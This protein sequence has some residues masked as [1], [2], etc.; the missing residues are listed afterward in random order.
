MR[1]ATGAA[2]LCLAA[3]VTAQTPGEPEVRRAIPVAPAVQPDDYEN[4][5]WVQ[6]VSPAN[7]T[8]TP[9]P[10]GIAV[11]AEP[12]ATPYRPPARSPDAAPPAPPAPPAVRQPEEDGSIRIAPANAGESPRAKLDLAN[13]LYSRK[14]FD[15][16]IPEYELYLISGSTDS[17]DAA[18]FRLA[19][20]H[21]MLGNPSAARAGYEKLVMEFHKGE[22]AG[23][24]AYRLGEIL[25]AAGIYDAACLQ[26][27][28]ASTEAKESEVRLTAK[29]FQARSL[30]YLK[31][32]EEA[33]AAYRSVA[34]AEGKNPYREH[35]LMAL[36][37]IDIR[38]GRKEEGFASLVKI[39][40]AKSAL[41][42]EA[43]VK[44]AAL[45]AELGRRDEALKLFDKIAKADDAPDWKPVALI[46]AMRLRY[47]GGDYRGVIAMG[48]GA[49]EAMPKD[50][51][52]EAFQLLAASYRQTGNNLEAR[53]TY[54]RLLKDF[55]DAAPAADARLQRLISLYALNDK[56]LVAEVD[57]FLEK[58]TDP[59]ARTQAGLLK[60][61]TFYKAGNF[62]AAG[63]LYKNL[64]SKDMDPAL[65]ADVLFKLGW[66]LSSTG[67]TTG[68]VSAFSEF[69]EKYPAHTLAAG[70]LAQRA[71]AHQQ[72]KA[73]DAALGD[74]DLL[75]SKYPG[76]REHELALQQ[77]ALI[78]GQNK[79][80]AAMKSEFT[81][82]LEKFPKTA[83]AA[84]A[85]FW[86]GWAAFEEKDYKG[87]V[88][89]LDRARKLDAAQYAER[90][91]LRIILAYYY[92]QDRAAVTREAETYKG[93]NLPPDIALWLAGQFF[94]EGNYTKAEA[95]L[96]PVAANPGAVPPEA[97]IQLAECRVRIGKFQDARAPVV[98]YLEAARDP[99][100]RA[101]GLLVQARIELAARNAGAAKGLVE[102]ALLLQPEGPLNAEARLLS[103]DLMFAKSDYDGAAR[104]YMS[105]ALLIDDPTITPRALQKAADAYRKVNNT[106]EA[107]RAMAELRERFPDFQK[108]AKTTKDKS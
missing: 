59:K 106:F 5:P 86:L 7:A 78:H 53:R 49:I 29:Y 36:A 50:V 81:D 61:E 105:V 11:P 52:P 3:G 58:T 42:A 97:L 67:D 56:N 51:Q 91:T 79:D 41:A 54:D 92:L 8:P 72:A 23:A 9:V 47:Q 95:L 15:L 60:A 43:S 85:N 104:A 16:A 13:S 27:E 20:S 39:A 65:Q 62:A 10:T 28:T 100:T 6:R 77:K 101:R 96:A 94:D 24:G 88:E 14:M 48:T 21:R 103:G 75:I 33:A 19:E 93:T 90:A 83:A 102:E 32:A 34:D 25:F 22:F 26:F 71:L 74:F 66:C 1:I 69:L 82:L 17:R 99:A 31:R 35:A 98:K 64:L 18:L 87:S 84:Q 57:A 45:A 55:P 46:G 30:D 4:P 76:T 68:A 70:A 37:D 2:F 12:A 38:A 108:S 107:D 80:Y 73:F 40:S 89:F 63:E 44:A